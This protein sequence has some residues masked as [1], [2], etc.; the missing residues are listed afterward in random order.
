M[1]LHY[2]YYTIEIVHAQLKFRFPFS[3]AHGTR[4]H[5]DAVLCKLDFAG[6]TGVGEATLPPYLPDTVEG[7]MAFLSSKELH[8]LL[9]QSISKDFSP[10][11]IFDG[12]DK[13]MP[14]HMPAKA[15]LD[16]ALWQLKAK[17][18][19]KTLTELLGVTSQNVVPHTYTIGISTRDEMRE[20]IQ[21]A[22]TNGFSFFKLKMNGEDDENVLN[23]FLALSTEPFAVDANQ[24]WNDLQH[25][26]TFSTQLEESGCVLIEQPFEKT[27][28]Q[29]SATL[30]QSL[31]IP[32][33]A[34]EACQ[35]IADIDSI[36]G[37]FCG[38]NIKLQKC[39]GLTEAMR[40]IT[41][42]KGLGLK[43]LIGCMSES[44][45]GCGAAE[46]LAPICDWADL[47]G[48][49]LIENN[50]EIIQFENLRI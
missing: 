28:R 26:I 1:I 24:G 43:T 15:A 14:G 19:N 2:P 37:A 46:A 25:A 3:I 7:V 50:E 44:S 8:H 38:I 40:M 36:R 48:P 33:I 30:M 42:A 41:H 11:R 31:H 49:W 21:F 6:H 22:E 35:R 16:M 17:I 18:E 12:I 32:V 29:K 45:I 23:D 4:T 27:D 47:D 10:E 39:G 9:A 20:K 13:L 5:T 34:D